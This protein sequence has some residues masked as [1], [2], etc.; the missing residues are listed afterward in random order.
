MPRPRSTTVTELSG[1]RV[2][3]TVVVAARERLVDGVVD[4]LVDEVVE[5]ARA[6]RADVHPGPEPD[7]LE[8]LQNGD[9]FCGIC[10]FGHQKSPANEHLAGEKQCIR[11]AGRIG[12]LASPGEARRGR[13]RD[14]LAQLLVLDR[15]GELGGLGAVL[16]ADSRSGSARAARR[17]RRRAPASVPE[18][19]ASA[20]GVASPSSVRSCSRIVAAR[21]PSSNAHVAEA[22]FT[23]SVPSRARRAGHAFRATV[24]PTARRPDAHDRRHVARPSARSGRARGAPGGRAAPSAAAHRCR[25]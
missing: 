16:G 18:R 25:A 24:S 15:G 3:S 4:D 10:G 8:A 2:T 6:R 5:A 19:S 13:S 20:G 1:W 21:R 7:G 22:V 23:C 17:P 12:R 11:N 14:E 9:V